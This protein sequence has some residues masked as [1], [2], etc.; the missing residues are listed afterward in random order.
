[1]VPLFTPMVGEKWDLAVL[2]S[3]F[4]NPIFVDWLM[5]INW[6]VMIGETAAEVCGKAKFVLK[7]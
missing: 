4:L 3:L 1:M 6:S 7:C 5:R 2:V